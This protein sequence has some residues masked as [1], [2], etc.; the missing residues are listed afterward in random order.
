MK[1]NG[2]GVVVLMAALFGTLAYPS[3]AA[4]PSHEEREKAEVLAIFQ[5]LLAKISPGDGWKYDLS[6]IFSGR[7][8]ESGDSQNQPKPLLSVREALDPD[9]KHPEQFCDF[10]ERSKTAREMAREQRGHSGSS[11]KTADTTFSYPIFSEDLSRATVEHQD[12]NDAWTADG[13]ADFVASGGTILLEKKK[14]RWQIDRI[15]D[16]WT[17]N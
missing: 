1:F 10:K 9:R 7:W 6:C 8:G 5:V 2:G 17:A 3:Q 11:V 13:P 16:G 15:V 14:G 12:S 4:S